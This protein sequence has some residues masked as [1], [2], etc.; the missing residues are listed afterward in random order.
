[1][2]SAAKLRAKE[3]NV[4]FA[5]TAEDIVIPAA[6]PLLGIPLLGKEDGKPGP[7]PNSPSLDR[8]VPKEGYVPG[9]VWVI[10]QRAN[11][12]KGD[13][14]LAEMKMLAANLA[15]SFW[16]GKMV[17]L[18]SPYTH[19][20]KAVQADRFLAVVK[21]CGWLMVNS[22]DAQMIYSPIA[23]T[24]PIADNCVLPGHWGFWET[25][26]KAMLSRCSEIW[27]FCIPGWSKSTGVKAE[28]KIASDY[29]LATRF[30][31]AQQDGTYAI[32]DTEPAGE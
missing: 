18:A 21:A 11:T 27:V 19:A 4:P 29:G 2:L 10:S 31:V 24:H 16:F 5:I 14:S 12:I 3:H 6:C 1:M 9:N 32:T 26:D 25:C 8:K 17:Y 22:S 13:A 15:K 7:H 28:R 20:D 30:I 23:H